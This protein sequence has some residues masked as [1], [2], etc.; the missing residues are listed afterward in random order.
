MLTPEDDLH[1]AL[2]MFNIRNLDELPVVAEDDAQ[3]L[4]GMLPRRSISRAYNQQ[5]KELDVLRRENQ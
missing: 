5:L 3:H 1:T 4:P 2:T